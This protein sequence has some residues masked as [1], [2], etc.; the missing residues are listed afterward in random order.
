MYYS[1]SPKPFFKTCT[2]IQEGFLT[3]LIIIPVWVLHEE[4]EEKGQYL[5]SI[6]KKH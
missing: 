2:K 4:F 3:F 6:D 1:F 5:G